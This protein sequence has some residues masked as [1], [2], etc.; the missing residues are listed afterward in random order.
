MYILRLPPCFR[1]VSCVKNNGHYWRQFYHS[2]ALNC[3]S[4]RSN[5]PEQYVEL[6]KTLGS[7]RL[8]RGAKEKRL[9]KLNVSTKEYLYGRSPC[10]GALEANR[11]RFYAIYLNEDTSNIVSRLKK[12]KYMAEKRNVAI[13]MVPRKRLDDLCNNRPHQNI[14]MKVGNLS[15]IPLEKKDLNSRDLDAGRSP[16]RPPLWLVLQGIQD[17]MNL[18]AILRTSAYLGV[19]KVVTSQSDSCPLTPAVSKAS[20]GA[21]EGLPVYSTNII[22]LLKDKLQKNWDIIG[23]VHPHVV[24]EG[25]RCTPVV[26]CNQFRLEKPSLLVL[27]NE[28]S[29]LTDQVQALCTKFL[30][31][32]P[33]MR[34]SFCDLDSLNVS[35]ATG[36]LLHSIF[37]P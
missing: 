8:R 9:D 27:G 4:Q 19:D 35:V 2:H 26:P 7:S 37:A 21:M 16:N 1:V 14:V 12:L 29:G 18:G 5:V 3:C 10:M 25:P 36:I 13:K 30:T 23:T 17:P 6:F 33:Q 31:I 34:H 32:Q 15:T 24:P 22:Q 20:A 11:R 28:G